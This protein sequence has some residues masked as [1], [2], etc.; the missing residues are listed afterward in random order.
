MVLMIIKIMMIKG[1]YPLQ[2]TLKNIISVNEPVLDNK[3][4][5]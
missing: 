5:R 4:D 1:E 2:W 3:C